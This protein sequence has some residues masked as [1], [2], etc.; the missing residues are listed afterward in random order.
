[1]DSSDM[2]VIGIVERESILDYGDIHGFILKLHRT[3]APVRPT[4]PLQIALVSHAFFEV[5]RA[6]TLLSILMQ[7]VRAPG[8]NS[9]RFIL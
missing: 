2:P 5:S 6:I 8:K 3:R 7:L 4:A 1:M 9:L